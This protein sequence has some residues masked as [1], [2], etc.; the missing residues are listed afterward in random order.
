MELFEDMLN[1]GHPNSIGRTV[2]VVNHV[3]T[4]PE[5]FEELYQCYF[6]NDEVVRLSVSNTMQ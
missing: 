2:E 1:G 6:S 5:K 4:N 3:L